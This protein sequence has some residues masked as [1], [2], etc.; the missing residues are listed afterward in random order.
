MAGS[1]QRSSDGDDRDQM[2]RITV[3]PTPSQQNSDTDSYTDSNS[4]DEVNATLND[5]EDEFNDTE[6]A[7]TEWSSTGPS[8]SSATRSYTGTGTFTGT[9][10]TGSPSY[11]TLPTV[12]LRSTSTPPVD[13]R[14]RLSKI[15]ERTEESSRP[16]SAALSAGTATR[17][18]NPTPDAFRRSVLLGGT[19]SSHSRSSTDP[20]LPPPGRANELIAVFET[21][22][23]QGRNASTPGERVT[24]PF[25]S[26]S[27]GS[28]PSSPS[29][30]SASY[31]ATDTRP[32]G[33]SFLSP[34]TRPSTSMS[35]DGTFRSTT[36]GGTFSR[37]TDSYL[38][39]SY[40]TQ[41]P[42]TFSRATYT[43]TNA[44]TYTADSRTYTG[45]TPSYTTQSPSTFS[46]TTYTD[47]NAPTYTGTDTRTYTG[48][49]TRTYT[50]TDT[51]TFTT[52]T[53]AGAGTRP[54][55]DTF[56]GTS[57]TPTSTLRR[58]QTSPRSPL[59][60]VRN[61]VA[62]WKERT[63]SKSRSPKKS[64][65]SAGSISP[66]PEA[67]GLFGKR[68]NIQ[69][70][71]VTPTRRDIDNLPPGL[72]VEDLLPYTQSTEAPL[73]IGQLWY[74][75]VHD[76]PPFRW[77]RCQ[78]LLYPQLL[79]L[80][81]LSPGGGRGIVALD[82]LNCTNVQSAPSPTHPSA[83]DDIGTIAAKS[84]SLDRDGQPL[85]D[86]LVPFHMLYAD[87][88]ERLG[89]ESLLERQRWVTRLW[90]SVNRPIAMPDS[91]SVT[92]SPTGSI[93]T[94]LS[95]DSRSSASSTASGSRSTVYVPPLR[96]LPSIPDF[97][98]NV[99]S[100]S[101]RSDGLTRST[102]ILSS[103][104]TRTVDDTV[105]SNQEYVYTGD[106]RAIQPARTG[107]QRRRSGSMTDLDAEFNSALTRARG[108]RPGLGFPSFV[109]GGSPVT[110][111][112][113]PNLGRD[114]VV[115]PPP[116]S[117]RGSDRAR[118][119]ISDEQF[120]T[121]GSSTEGSRSS[122]YSRT[123]FTSDLRTSTGFRTDAPSYTYDGTSATG[124]LAVPSTLSYRGTNSTSY[125]G[126]SHDS[127]SYTGTSPSSL[128]RTREVRRRGPRSVRTYSSGYLTESSASD[129]EN[130]SGTYTPESAT[131][132][133]DSRSYDSGS[134][135]PSSEAH[136]QLS[137]SYTQ[138]SGSYTSR[139][140]S[141]T[142]ETRSYTDSGSYTPSGSYTSD[143]Y[144]PSGSY[145]SRSGIRTGSDT[146]TPG[147]SSET[148][149]DICHSSDLTDL[150]GRIM[151]SSDDSLTP[152]SPSPSSE[153]EP[154]QAGVD[155]D[156]DDVYVDTDENFVTASQG[157]SDYISARTP[158]LKGSVLSREGSQSS[159]AS[160]PT[161]PSESDYNTADTGYSHYR[162]ISEPSLGSE[163]ITAEF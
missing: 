127:M 7:L 90:E 155:L 56:T 116:G 60:S 8:Y 32:T 43:D 21:N 15:T 134:Y 96:S 80:S 19:S 26:T 92:R 51:R 69:N 81:W 163:Y 144:T 95:I 36:P 126:D 89:T 25:Y 33:S 34:A 108:A 35:G 85:M 159:Y 5:L 67:E 145:S 94:I 128:S 125:L 11:V 3:S 57:V 71:P 148:G 61:I 88:V 100:R 68:G 138:G 62:L 143:S 136:S 107:S 28:R 29:K 79:L 141:Y 45:T 66:P 41:S 91:S 1:H 17:P 103:H 22:S 124:T 20:G 73:Y 70:N 10:Y 48:T 63:P 115:T 109:L 65:G 39:P 74:L 64:A 23:P 97:S 162:T 152:Y 27:Y 121:A 129:K 12:T 110:V 58:P 149:Y 2:R 24:S 104:F 46:R 133:I 135:T 47:T 53:R 31:T 86:M 82:L 153:Y 147:D 84:Q 114:V 119:E 16:V 55:T 77:Q 150:T 14:A 49:D 50:G 59:T 78:A 151:T 40:T 117:S 118:S 52:D 93:R 72:D 105:I 113:G 112:S 6:Q 106:P 156:I 30:S 120:F 140:G 4:I 99:S 83:R 87:G 54:Y 38:T 75:N 98:S 160:F 161:I 13:P 111:S 137:G 146:M 132:S 122:Y 123:S 142:S 158:S 102:S 157:S 131:Q 42:S 130:M 154:E 76:S 18:A 9:G 44:P 101:S 37:T 139:S